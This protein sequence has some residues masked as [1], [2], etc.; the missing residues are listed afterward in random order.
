MGEKF[1]PELRAVWL[2]YSSET[3]PDGPVAE[4]DIM[5][6]GTLEIGDWVHDALGLSSCLSSVVDVL[7]GK[8]SA[9]NMHPNAVSNFWNNKYNS[10]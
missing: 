9:I 1:K 4:P 7:I 8:F 5:G 6:D 10:K 3:Y 2:A